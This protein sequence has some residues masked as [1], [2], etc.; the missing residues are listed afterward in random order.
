[1]VRKTRFTALGTLRY[2][3]CSR[4]DRSSHHLSVQLWRSGWNLPFFILLPNNIC[5]DS[6]GL[7]SRNLCRH[8]SW[9][10][11]LC[12]LGN[13]F[14]TH[15]HYWTSYEQS[16][17]GI[18]SVFPV[19]LLQFFG[20]HFCLLFLQ[21]IERLD[22]QAE[23]GTLCTKAYA[24]CHSNNGTISKAR[25]LHLNSH[26]WRYVY[27]LRRVKPKQWWRYLPLRPIQSLKGEGRRV[28]KWTPQN[29]R[30]C[31]YATT[32]DHHKQGKKSQW[33]AIWRF[34]RWELWKLNHNLHNL[35]LD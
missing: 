30:K 32:K 29:R 23:K 22:R 19:W 18:R 24:W 20:C 13:C 28:K 31:N 3:Y 14:N 34:N 11:N 7:R 16:T 26:R 17:L 2:D 12:A 10:G 4:Y 1:M 27:G 9:S 35:K 15:A 6:L 5:L 25:P 33:K 8:H 21:R